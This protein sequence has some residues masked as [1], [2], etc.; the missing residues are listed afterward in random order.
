MTKKSK[1]KKT[2]KT[3]KVNIKSISIVLLLLFS[4][5]FILI[6]GNNTGFIG[7]RLKSLFFYLRYCF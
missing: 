3:N 1:S 5:A 6:V 4:L 7:Y 2:N